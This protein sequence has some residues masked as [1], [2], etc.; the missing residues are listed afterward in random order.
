MAKHVENLQVTES[1]P[2]WTKLSAFLISQKILCVIVN[3]WHVYVY[4]YTD[5]YVVWHGH[6]YHSWKPYI[7]IYSGL[8]W[9][10]WPPLI[11]I[12]WNDHHPLIIGNVLLNLRIT[13]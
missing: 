13:R 12:D 3:L 7:Y 6:P 8:L 11:F 5:I 2:L 1:T 9:V 10:Y 4:I